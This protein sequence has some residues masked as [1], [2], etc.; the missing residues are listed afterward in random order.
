AWDPECFS[1][2]RLCQWSLEAGAIPDALELVRSGEG[3]LLTGP[4]ARQLNLSPGDS[5]ELRSPSGP[6]A[7]RIVAITRSAVAS[8]LVISRARYR[9]AWKDDMTTWLYVAIAADADLADVQS[10]IGRRLGTGHRL[11]IRT[12]GAFV[13]HLTD[14]ARQAFRAFLPMKIV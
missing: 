9:P 3:A 10:E 1:D 5:I 14:Q 4:L 7:F 6:Q 2:K 13:D 12:R 11:R 8:A